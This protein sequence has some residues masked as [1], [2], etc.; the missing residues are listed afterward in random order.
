MSTL[1][2]VYK[3][4]PGPH[5]RVSL[6]TPLQETISARLRDLSMPSNSNNNKRLKEVLKPHNTLTVHR[7]IVS[8]QIIRTTVAYL[9]PLRANHTISRHPTP[10]KHPPDQVHPMP[11]P[12]LISPILKPQWISSNWVSKPISPTISPNQQNT[13]KNPPPWVGAAGLGCSCGD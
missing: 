8:T 13:L 4:R 1:C 7:R 9:E 6:Y 3:P 11:P 5:R 2:L 12:S 10:L